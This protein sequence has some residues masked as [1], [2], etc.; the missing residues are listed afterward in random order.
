[1][2]ANHD[3]KGD[4]ASSG[5]NYGAMD[6]FKRKA[7]QAAIST[8]PN[9]L[10]SP[11]GL[12]VLQQSY[13][14]SA[15]AVDMGRFILAH[16]ME[17]LGTKNKVAEATRLMMLADEMRTETNRS[18]YG[19]V[20]QC[21][22]AMIINDLLTVGAM[23][24][25]ILMYMAAGDSAFF[26]DEVATQDLVDGFKT[27][28][29]LSGVVWGGGET[30]TLR[31]IIM[32]GTIDLAGSA[33]GI[34]YPKGH[35][36]DS[37]N[38]RVGDAIVIVRSSGVHANGIT[39]VRDVASSLPRGYLTPLG[40]GKLFGEAILTPTTIYRNLMWAVF[41]Q[42]IDVHYI[43]NVTGHGWRKFMRPVQPFTYVFDTV[44]TPQPEFLL[45]QEVTGM[46][47]EQIY[48]D[49]NMGAGFALYVSPEQATDVVKA[50]YVAGYSA[51]ISGYVDEPV[52]NQ[53]RVVIGP[54]NIEYSGESLQLR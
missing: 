9:L 18:F 29:D 48:G 4:Y 46:T 31:D 11:R 5:V 41:E 42:R 13:G 17:G 15:F 50:A 27:A 21:D 34:V 23:P 1:M 32:P 39:K 6:P 7:L 53:K 38:I 20:A 51:E 14:E 12:Q 45:V 35:W 2:T 3:P 10:Q 49:Y 40:N 28:C 24:L 36:V 25:T 8:V 37:A 22:V 44:P 52:N 19:N 16:V 54:K 43:V 26:E 30:P 33:T 47:D